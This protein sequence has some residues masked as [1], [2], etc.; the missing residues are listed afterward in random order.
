MWCGLSNGQTRF[1]WSTYRG[2]AT[3]GEHELITYQEIDTSPIEAYYAGKR[4]VSPIRRI[5]IRSAFR[6][7]SSLASG[8]SIGSI[9]I[10]KVL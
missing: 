4:K 8:S 7:D 3:G 1:R 6:A 10:G 2:T 9:P 5:A